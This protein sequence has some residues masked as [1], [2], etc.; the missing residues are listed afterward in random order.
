MCLCDHLFSKGEM[1]CNLAYVH[2][3]SNHDRLPVLHP[4]APVCSAWP[5]AAFL[6]SFYSPVSLSDTP[7]RLRVPYV[8]FVLCPCPFPFPTVSTLAIFTHFLYS[9]PLVSSPPPPLLFCPLLQSFPT[10]LSSVLLLSVYNGPGERYSVQHHGQ[11]P[12]N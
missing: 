9:T 4:F 6:C 2:L 5:P 10:L 1:Y 7:V 8:R 12:A 11:L 3:I